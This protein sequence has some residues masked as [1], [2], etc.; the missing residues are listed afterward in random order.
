MNESAHT[1]QQTQFKILLIGD[2]CADIYLYGTV[3]R[4]SPEAPVPVFKFSHEEMRPGMGGNVLKN[5][6]A[7]GCDVQFLHNE[8]SVKTRF[9]D[10]RSRQ[11]IVRLDDDKTCTPLTI[12]SLVPSLYDA[13]VI[14]DYNK[15]TVT[16][17]LV[18]ELRKEFK[19]PIF[20]DTKKHDLKRFEG[21]IVKIN[22]HEFS[23]LTS[24]PSE[25]TDLIV[26]YSGDGV[27]WGVHAF[28]AKA[29]EV[30]D[31]CG[32]GDTFL[33]A[34][35]YQYLNTN[36]VATAIQFAIKASAVTVQHLGCYAPTLKEINE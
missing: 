24:Q 26:T 36:D 20:V 1:Q 5:L 12:D 18:E 17:E 22:Q 10:I 30:A 23:N 25:D 31:V 9:I 29:V 33:S 6:E 35:C 19:G 21:C 4:I 7:L 3:D 28:A 8:T 2:N 11:H 34:L 27:V 32:A 16:Y 15:G 13:I 14:S